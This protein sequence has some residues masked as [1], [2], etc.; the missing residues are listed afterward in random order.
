MRWNCPADND[1]N[2]LLLLLL[3]LILLY[4]VFW[5]MRGFPEGILVLHHIIS[6]SRYKIQLLCSIY[7]IVSVEV[8]RRELRLG[9]RII[10]ERR[11]L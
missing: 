2:D 8:D 1:Q 10:G 3:L 7:M 4:F 9:P 11:E 5:L 6:T